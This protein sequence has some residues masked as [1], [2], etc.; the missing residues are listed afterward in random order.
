MR[1][2]CDIL[3]IHNWHMRGVIAFNTIDRDI[4]TM[5]PFIREIR[6]HYS[7]AIILENCNLERK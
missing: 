7:T 5:M 1:V 2:Q 6:G 4:S 3:I